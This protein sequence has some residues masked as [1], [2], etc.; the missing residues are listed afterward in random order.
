MQRKNELSSMNIVFCLLVIFIH[1]SSAPVT[2]LSKESW[3][4]AVFFVPWRLSAFVVQ[5]FIFLSG[6][7]MFLKEDTKRYNMICIK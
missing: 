1:V 6:L 2:G 7:K 3:Q 5:G 4:Y